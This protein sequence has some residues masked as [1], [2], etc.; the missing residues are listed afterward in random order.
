MRWTDLAWMR[1][2]EEKTR[3]SHIQGV[4]KRSEWE[5]TRCC[6]RKGEREREGRLSALALEVRGTDYGTTQICGDTCFAVCGVGEQKCR[7]P[8]LLF[9]SHG[10]KIIELFWMQR[11]FDYVFFSLFVISPSVSTTSALRPSSSTAPR[12]WRATPSCSCTPPC[13]SPAAD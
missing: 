10:R 1:G 12:C 5:R 11:D 9:V 3:L 8:F 6:R 2:R 7:F 4:G 13:S